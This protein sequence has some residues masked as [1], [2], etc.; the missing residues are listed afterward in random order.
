[1]STY[2]NDKPFESTNNNLLIDQIRIC[3]ISNHNA[4]KYKKFPN[5]RGDIELEVRNGQL[6]KNVICKREDMLDEEEVKTAPMSR[7]HLELI[8]NKIT[9][10]VS[11]WDPINYAKIILKLSIKDETNLSRLEIGIRIEEHFKRQ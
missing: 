7:K 1:M 4:G 11:N 9:E 3:I 6:Q 2:R 8:L 5:G 10:R